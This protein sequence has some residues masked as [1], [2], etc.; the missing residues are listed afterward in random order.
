MKRQLIAAAA[1][2][3]L[4][5]APASAHE[6]PVTI[7]RWVDADTFDGVMEMG[8]GLMIRSRFR[9]MCINAPES[10]GAR[11]SPEGVQMSE[12]VKALLIT[13]GTVDPLKRDA[14][15][16]ILAHLKPKGWDMTLNQRLLEMGAP[17]YHGLTKKDR[18]EC[19][20]RLE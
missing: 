3:V 19:E 12:D 9:L 16:R 20:R 17:Y 4:W 13:E 7:S 2:F 14:F 18:A 5:S 15:G 8:F 10:G 1:C 6:Y 11:K